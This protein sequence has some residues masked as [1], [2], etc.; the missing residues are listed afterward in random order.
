MPGTATLAYL[1][2]N[3]IM[4]LTTQDAQV[5][6]FVNVAAHLAPGGV[7]VMEVMVP[8]L[9]RL[10]PGETVRP[11]TVTPT[12]LGFEEY[13]VASSGRL[14]P[15]LDR[16]RRAETSRRRSATCGPPSSTLWRVSLG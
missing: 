7:F 8:D 10:P 9:Q 5:A 4:N 11:F 12:H 6:C 15:L 3:T 2:R 1:V 16:R 14:L 13:D